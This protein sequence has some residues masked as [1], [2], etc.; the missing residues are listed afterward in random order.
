M[1]EPEK[2]K[3]TAQISELTFYALFYQVE[4][5][6]RNLYLPIVTK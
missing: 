2:N 4:E 1:I 5:S 6:V 3:V